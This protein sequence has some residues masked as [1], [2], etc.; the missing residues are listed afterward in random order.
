MENLPLKSTKNIRDP[1]YDSIVIISTNLETD[2]EDFGI[3]KHF[4]ELQKFKKVFFVAF[5]I[6]NFIIYRINEFLLFK[7]D[8]KFEKN[9]TFSIINDKRV[10]NI[11]D[12]TILYNLID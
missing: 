12:N 3:F 4:E 8:A 1:E 5:V 9:V 7:N 11:K 6:I 10:V 2:L